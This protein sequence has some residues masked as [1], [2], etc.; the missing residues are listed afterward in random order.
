MSTPLRDRFREI[1]ERFTSAATKKAPDRLAPPLDAVLLDEIAGRLDEVHTALTTELPELR[2]SMDGVK[3][4]LDDQVPKGLQD[5]QDVDVS[6]NLSS[7]SPPEP[8]FSAD[9]KNDGDYSIWYS[10]NDATRDFVE[11][12]KKEARV[13]SMGRALITKIW[14]K[15]SAGETSTVRI[16]GTF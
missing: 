16:T 14:F 3:Q 1:R 8:L 7:Y 4:R 9:I 10:L 2:K 6:E 15:C 11:L 5:Q 13:V 12:K